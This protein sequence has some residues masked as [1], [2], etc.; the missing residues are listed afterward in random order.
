MEMILA[1]TLYFDVSE[2]AQLRAL[3]VLTYSY[4]FLM[5]ASA[6]LTVMVDVCL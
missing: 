1:A 5:Y 6:S 2:E 4:T 3:K